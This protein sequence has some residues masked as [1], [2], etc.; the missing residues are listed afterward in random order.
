MVDDFL[1]EDLRVPSRDEVAG[2]M[3][4]LRRPLV[5]DGE[6]RECPRCGAYRDWI[7]LSIRD[8]VWLRC[9][10]S[11]ETLEHRLDTAWFNRNS[12]PMD[13]MHATF[14]DGLKYLG[15]HDN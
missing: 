6:V 8:E 3:M 14:E 11:H 5:I 12:G 9:R 4:H 7:I 13:A 2:M 10:A 15:H 1:P